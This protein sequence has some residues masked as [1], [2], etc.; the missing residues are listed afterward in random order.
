M[1]VP[2]P[3]SSCTTWESKSSRS[4]ITRERS[5]RPAVSIYHSSSGTLACTIASRV[6]PMNSGPTQQRSFQYHATCLSRLR[7]SAS[8]PLEWPPTA[9]S[10]PCRRRER[11]DHAR[12]RPNLGTTPGRDLRYS[13]YSSQ[14][15]RR[16]G[17]LLR[18]GAGAPAIVLGG[19][20]SHAPRVS[21]SRSRLRTRPRAEQGEN[22]S[23]RTA[24]MAIGVERVRGAKESRGLFP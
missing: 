1:S 15:G 5:I 17:Q 21:S 22:L 2:S 3:R 6:I 19:G 16:G 11:S 23:N 18:V 12:S 10:H 13:R 24:A 14:F 20:G 9:L 7:W 8:S 4:A